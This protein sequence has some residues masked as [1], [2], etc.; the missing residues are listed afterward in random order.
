MN[1]ICIGTCV[2]NDIV[3]KASESGW[4]NIL[5]VLDYSLL[6]VVDNESISLEVK[7]ELLAF[8]DSYGGGAEKHNSINGRLIRFFSDE[9]SKS[10]IEKADLVLCDL[11]D[12]RIDE[13]QFCV[14]EYGVF[15]IGTN[16]I[17]GEMVNEISDYLELKLGI[18]PMVKTIRMEGLNDWQLESYI[19]RY[20]IY[21]KRLFFEK[22]IVFFKPKLVCNYLDYDNNQIKYTPHCYIQ[23]SVNRQIDRIYSIAKKYTDF[24]KAPEFLIGDSRCLLPFEFHFS[25]YYYKYMI[26]SIGHLCML[27]SFT[28]DECIEELRQYYG[29]KIAYSYNTI[30]CEQIICKLRDKGILDKKIILLAQNSIFGDIINDKYNLKLFDYIPY[31]ENTLLSDLEHIINVILIENNKN[32]LAFVVPE[33]FS[34]KN[35]DSGIFTMMSK[36]GLLY[37]VHWFSY[38][39]ESPYIFD[40][41]KGGFVDIFNNEIESVTENRIILNGKAVSMFISQQKTNSTI[42][43]FDEARVNCGSSSRAMSVDIK[44]LWDSRLEIGDDCSSARADCLKIFLNLGS[45]CC[46]GNDVMFSWGITI[47][48]GDGHTIFEKKNDDN[49]TM[50]NKKND[51]VIIG[52]HV[53][54]GFNSSII[55]GAYIGECS[56]VGACSLVNKKIPNNAIVAGQPA[57]IV[58]RNIVWSRN[59]C[60]SDYNDE[61]YLAQFDNSS[62]DD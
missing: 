39:F 36:C 12:F 57:K 29:Y 49:Y 19:K 24:L 55:T 60:I 52:D 51:R 43:L 38:E 4:K 42:T 1:V 37:N 11:V 32:S 47:V 21:L 7:N 45:R 20:I 22:R 27:E 59:V 48:C 41:F 58:R 44:C 18:R 3:D 14:G 40:G 9:I 56:I 34:H 28:F 61:P 25:D 6:S 8:F 31:S 54:V 10:I 50:I 35:E 62:L 17:S 2:G 30:I 5:N 46:I 26:D 16:I 23:R 13:Y 33:F 53:W 15:S